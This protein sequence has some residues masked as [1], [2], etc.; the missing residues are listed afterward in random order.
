[1]TLDPAVAIAFNSFFFSVAVSFDERSPKV[2]LNFRDLTTGV[3]EGLV[4]GDGVADGVVVGLAEGDPEGLAD[5][6]VV[7][8]AEGDP[9]GLA[10]GVGVGDGVATE[11][12][13]VKA[14]VSNVGFLKIPA[15]A[16]SPSAGHDTEVNPALGLE[17]WTPAPNVAGMA[18]AQVPFV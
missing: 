10:E 1:M 15:A 17:S 11:L 5:G 9:E 18:L 4:E 12:S 3:T 6:V 13:S 2:T 7:G 16:Q 8:L 14:A